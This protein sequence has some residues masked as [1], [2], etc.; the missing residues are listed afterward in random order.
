MEGFVVRAISEIRKV[1]TR[2][3][4]ELL[5]EIDQTLGIESND[6]VYL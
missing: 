6:F 3:E 2:K 4:K 5:I 1:L